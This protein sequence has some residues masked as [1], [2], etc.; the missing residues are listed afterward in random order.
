MRF[1]V[2][3]YDCSKLTNE[4]HERQFYADSMGTIAAKAKKLWGW[5]GPSKKGVPIS[6]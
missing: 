2:T 6:S 4:L 5:Y 3:N 1:I